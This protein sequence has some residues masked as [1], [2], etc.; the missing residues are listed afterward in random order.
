LILPWQ[1][2]HEEMLDI[3]S[4]DV[5]QQITKGHGEWESQMPAEAA[6]MI[7]ENRWFNFDSA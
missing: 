4:R 2:A 6:E 1:G 5:L 7:I 3:F